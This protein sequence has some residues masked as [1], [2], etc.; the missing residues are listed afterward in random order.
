MTKWGRAGLARYRL[1]ANC[2][3]TLDPRG[4]RTPNPLLRDRQILRRAKTLGKLVGAEGF[5]PPTLCSQSIP[6]GNWGSGKPLPLVFLRNFATW[7]N[8]RKPRAATHCQPI[9]SRP[10]SRRGFLAQNCSHAQLSNPRESS[11]VLDVER[12][13]DV[14]APMARSSCACYV[15]CSVRGPARWLNWQIRSLRR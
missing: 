1:S 4:I 10:R 15:A 5:E 2:Q 8:P 11:G 7:G 6:W 9:V 12:T 13:A 14:L 3:P